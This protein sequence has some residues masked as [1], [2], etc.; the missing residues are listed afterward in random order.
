M[1][2]IADAQLYFSDKLWPDF[3]REDFTKAIEEYQRRQ[4]RFGK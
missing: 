2:D 4:R 3:T 1:W